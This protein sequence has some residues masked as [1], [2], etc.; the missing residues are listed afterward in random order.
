VSI[1]HELRRYRAP[2]N[3]RGRSDGQNEAT[4]FLDGDFLEQYLSVVSGSAEADAIL[5]G[6]N[7]AESIDMTDQQI[8]TLLESL[9]SLH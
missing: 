6:A 5:Q 4:G 2:A 3:M 7:A 1:A 9:Q 8:R